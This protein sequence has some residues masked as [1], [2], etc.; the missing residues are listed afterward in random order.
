MIALAKVRHASFGIPLPLGFLGL[1]NQQGDW[2]TVIKSFSWALVRFTTYHNAQRL[3][4]ISAMVI[5]LSQKQEVITTSD[6]AQYR[7]QELPVDELSR[8]Q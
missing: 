6:Y 2:M 8:C 5:L 4:I 7:L 1:V 3:S